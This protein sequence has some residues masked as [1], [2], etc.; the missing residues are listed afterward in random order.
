MKLCAPV[1]VF[2]RF[3][4]VRLTISRLKRQGV[5]PIIMGHERE[6]LDIS[7]EL[8]VEF[9]SIS[10]DPLGNK[11]NAGF[12]ACQNYSPDGVI[13]MGSS[14]WASDDYIQSVSDA[15]NDFAFIGMLGCHFADVSDEVRLVHWP[16]YAKGQRQYEPIG[17][18]RVLRADLLQK[19]NWQPFDPRLSS[20]LD[21]S[22]YLKTIRLVDEI[23]V[24]KDEEKDVRL[25]SI[26][27]DKWTNKHKFS[28]H[29]NGALKS[30]RC[31]VALLDNGFNELKSL[32]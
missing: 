16:G 18:G 3:P 12:M 2:G 24:I 19:I 4:L 11:W 21:W 25:L 22:M 8:N 13:F 7:K 20:G 23:A 31:D 15:L 14:D 5:I 28:D 6:A 10:N 27:T 9:I 29:W 26:S 30:E 32:L 17:I 1:P